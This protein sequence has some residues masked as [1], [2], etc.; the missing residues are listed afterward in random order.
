ML[1]GANVK[2]SFGERNH[3]L[4]TYDLTFQMGIIVILTGSVNGYHQSTF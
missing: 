1:A 4:P 3:Y 2:S